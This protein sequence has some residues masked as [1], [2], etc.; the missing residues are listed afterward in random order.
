MA[1]RWE[2]DSSARI[3]SCYDS[4]DEGDYV[5]VPETIS[6]P[7]FDANN[8]PDPATL[9][10]QLDDYHNKAK[11]ETAGD[12]EDDSEDDSAGDSAGESAGD[13]GSDSEHSRDEE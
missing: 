10:K 6:N 1:E 7:Y 4:D 12:S 9:D 3:V 11:D 8:A 5:K 2:D 13:S